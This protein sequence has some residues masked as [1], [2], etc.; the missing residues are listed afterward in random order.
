MDPFKIQ[1]KLNISYQYGWSGIKRELS[2]SNLTMALLAIALLA[3]FT[4][5]LVYIFSVQ[6]WK[7]TQDAL[8]KIQKE[9]TLLRK[10]LDYYAGVIDTIYLKLD[11]LQVNS[12]K[13]PLTGR[14]YSHF[15]QDGSVPIED[16]TFIY[17]SYL[18]GK[19]NAAEG[20]ISRIYA[21]LN[22]EKQSTGTAVAGKSEEIIRIDSGPSIFPTFGRW[23][24][25]WGVRMHPIYSKLAFHYG[26]DIANKI[27]TPIYAT[28]DGD[29][30][31]TSFDSDYGKL[32]RIEHSNNYETRY[33]HMYSFS[34]L[35][36]DRVRKGQI[37]GLMGSTGRS[38]GP[39]LHY[40]VLYAG[41][42]VNP[43]HFLNR[44]DDSVYYAH[45]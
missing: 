28:S 32:V 38:T 15:N 1:R 14:Y 18:D 40:E 2:V 35:P 42:K 12:G 20:Q 23:S 30:V 6:S 26:V 25:G 10:K 29:V 33:G 16:N 27:G 39:H 36:G 44:F 37:I 31:E 19:V 13:T 17:D 41:N 11:T 9:N 7:Q 4:L 21:C 8:V 34:V 43:S 3:V 24:D 5:S 45:R 22:M